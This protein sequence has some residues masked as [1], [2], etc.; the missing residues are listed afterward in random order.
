MP[1]AY[2]P[3]HGH[4]VQY[5]GIK[6]KE[7]PTCGQPMEM[8]A[9]AAAPIS[10]PTKSV[11]KTSGK[12]SWETE[13]AEVIHAI[14]S[15]AFGGMDLVIKKD[16]NDGKIPTIKDIRENGASGGLDL[17]ESRAPNGKGGINAAS[18]VAEMLKKS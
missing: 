2:C 4:K 7:C 6:P 15:E 13:T 10:I 9:S 11:A 3:C 17:R 5:T 18:L 12:Y 16:P 1:I 14:E 8:K